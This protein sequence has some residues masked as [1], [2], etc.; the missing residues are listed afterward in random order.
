[1]DNL[2]SHLAQGD[3]AQLTE[4]HH[5]DAAL[6]QLLDA[7]PND[8][9]DATNT[10]R[11]RRRVMPAIIAAAC[12]ILLAGFI[13]ANLW[14]RDARPTLP[15]TGNTAPV[16]ATETVALA[17]HNVTVAPFPVPVS[18]VLETSIVDELYDP[19][20]PPRHTTTFVLPDRTTYDVIW[21]GSPSNV[22]LSAQSE[23]DVRLHTVTFRQTETLTSGV[24]DALVAEWT[25]LARGGV[26]TAD[27]GGK[28]PAIA[29]LLDDTQPVLLS[30]DRPVSQRATALRAIADIPGLTVVKE[31]NGEHT[32]LRL[33][34]PDGATRAAPRTLHIDP[35]FGVLVAGS[36]SNSQRTTG[37]ITAVPPWLQRAVIAAQQGTHCAPSRD[38]QRQ[39]CHF[40]TT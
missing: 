7:L 26:V 29:K 35:Q 12:V 16:G 27:D 30:L 36:L 31:T 10:R 34:I 24:D 18:G 40:G 39:T 4:H 2:R 11:Q 21:T 15:A 9:A 22:P 14:P 8:G 1:M 19:D 5:N 25:A 20:A 28:T 32:H 33:S 3:P 6:H 13:T 23:G 37:R 17:G 38:Q